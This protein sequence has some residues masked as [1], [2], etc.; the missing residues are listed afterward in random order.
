MKV[1]KS[2]AVT[3]AQG[4]NICWSIFMADLP[5]VYCKFNLLTYAIS[6]LLLVTREASQEHNLSFF[7]SIVEPLLKLPQKFSRCANLCCMGCTTMLTER[8]DDRPAA[9]YAP[10]CFRAKPKILCMY[11]YHIEHKFQCPERNDVLISC[12]QFESRVSISLLRKCEM[13]SEITNCGRCGGLIISALVSGSSAPGSS[14][15][16]GHCVMFLGKTLNSH[17]ASLHSGV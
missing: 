6:T 15:E 17:S 16:Q 1:S 7:S 12:S 8:G 14:T 10:S 3:C 11:Q 4:N 13:F 5:K 2:Q 9:V